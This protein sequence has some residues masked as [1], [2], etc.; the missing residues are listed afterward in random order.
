[1]KRLFYVKD[2]KTGKRSECSPDFNNK[3]EAKVFRDNLNSGDSA[4]YVIS[5]GVD[6]IGNHGHTVPRM[7]RQPKTT[8]V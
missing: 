6:H 3:E 7:R 1:M 2:T 4:R 5:R 8:K